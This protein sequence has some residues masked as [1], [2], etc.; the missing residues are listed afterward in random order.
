SVDRRAGA[1]Y[2]ESVHTTTQG[3]GV[4]TRGTE[5]DT[6]PKG[7]AWALSDV[8]REH[9]FVPLRVEGP[10]PDALRGTMYGTGP[11]LFRL[12]E[13]RYRHWFDG[14]GLISAVRFEDGKALGASR[15]L[16]T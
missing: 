6:D 2:H 12:F 7:W 11:G 5:R 1:R 14:D 3:N 8:T 9:G 15:L 4:E 16:E 13:H 10:P